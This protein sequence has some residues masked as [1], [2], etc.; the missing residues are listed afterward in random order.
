MDGGTAAGAGLAERTD[1]RAL[2]RLSRRPGVDAAVTARVDCAP[3]E[4]VA[5][6]VLQPEALR[7]MVQNAV[8]YPRMAA[9]TG[10]VSGRGVPTSR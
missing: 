6:H 3:V 7:Q 5:R 10:A 1:P 8:S 2:R 4:Q 9:L